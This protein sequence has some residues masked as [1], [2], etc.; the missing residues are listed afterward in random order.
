MKAAKF[1]PRK[2]T[3]KAVAAMTTQ[4]SRV[5]RIHL[6]AVAGFMRI[7]LLMRDFPRPQFHFDSFSDSFDSKLTT[8]RRDA[9]LT[10]VLSKISQ[11][12]VVEMAPP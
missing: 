10:L 1:T 8:D 2:T 4:A 3:D 9:S 12:P 5:Q 7:G 6:L 11:P